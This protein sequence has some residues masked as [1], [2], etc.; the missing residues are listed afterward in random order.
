MAFGR[1]EDGKGEDLHGA[2]AVRFLYL[3]F[4]FLSTE[5]EKFKHIYLFHFAPFITLLIII[6]NIIKHKQ[7]KSVIV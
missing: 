1:A 5:N 6:Y 7:K 3:Y 4:K 2:G